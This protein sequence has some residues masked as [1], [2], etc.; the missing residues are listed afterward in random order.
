MHTRPVTT[1]FLG[2][3]LLACG[4]GSGATSPD[5]GA[6]AVDGSRPGVDAAG[7][8]AHV[9]PGQDGGPTGTDAAMADGGGSSS[10]SICEG[11]SGDANPFAGGAISV[12]PVSATGL[13][14]SEGP[15]WIGDAFYF[16]DLDRTADTIR[17]DTASSSR[18]MRYD[19]NSAPT[20]WVGESGSN[21]LAL[22]ADGNIVAAT[23]DTQS[24]SRY[25][26][27]DQARSQMVELNDGSPFNSPNDLDVDPTNGAIYFTDPTWQQ[28]GR[29]G[30]SATRV[31]RYGAGTL[32]VIDADASA[33]NGISLSWNGRELYV[34]GIVNGNGMGYV[35]VYHLATDGSVTSHERFV[36]DGDVG[37]YPDGMT[38]DCAGN[39][40]VTTKAGVEVFGTDG[41][42]RGII[43]VASGYLIDPA[44]V[45]FGGSD[46]RE[47]LV[48]AGT[49]LWRAH[50]PIP[51]RQN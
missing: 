16:S 1:L 10:G 19:L 40:Y 42:R 36:Q 49:N 47:L 8:D 27:S 29:N 50:M 2:S 25:A 15:V 41:A 21:G 26:I 34:G 9:D 17:W 20:V 6:T 24:I 38:M 11:W 33:P 13:R 18:I 45:A 46:H 5:G 3:A 28:D 12:E 14:G 39:L 35:E 23:H 48:T 4:P 31:Y 7:S 30:Q 51:G 32:S 22:G 37:L 44:N 43:A